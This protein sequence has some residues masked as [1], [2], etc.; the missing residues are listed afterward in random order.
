MAANNQNKVQK[1]FGGYWIFLIIASIFILFQFIGSKKP[2]ETYQ[3]EF[4]NKMLKGGDVA[5]ID[6]IRDKNLV[7]V[8]I[9]PDSIE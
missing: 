9:K 5:Q 7:N 1:F 2:V 6:I 8:T 3:Q 4:M